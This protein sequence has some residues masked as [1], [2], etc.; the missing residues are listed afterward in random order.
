MRIW[1]GLIIVAAAAL[2]D[3]HGLRVVRLLAA[4]QHRR[5]RLGPDPAD[6]DGRGLGL[7]LRRR[8][9]PR[10]PARPAAEA[11]PG[12][13][14]AQRRPLL[15]RRRLA[16]VRLP[17]GGR[18]EGLHERDVHRRRRHRRPRRPLQRAAA[19]RRLRLRPLGPAT[20]QPLGREH[21]CRDRRDGAL[22][23]APQHAELPLPRG[24]DHGRAVPRRL[25]LRRRVRAE[26]AGH[27][28]RGPQGACSRASPTPV[29]RRP[30][31]A[32]RGSPGW[33]STTTRW[34]TCRASGG[35]SPRS[36]A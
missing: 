28:G 32:S 13:G 27:L 35:W 3:R 30:R 12:D 2:R 31:R 7:P 26:L 36:A 4:E 14:R 11:A 21:R 20:G 22:R 10:R 25:R 1:F 24:V 17:R 8:L 15:R 23:P 18:A 9:A 29:S 19:R 5:A 6:V 33:R 16:P 34:S